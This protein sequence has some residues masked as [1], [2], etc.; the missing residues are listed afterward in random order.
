MIQKSLMAGAVS[1]ALA[2]GAAF[3]GGQAAQQG[4]QGGFQQ[5][6]GQGSAAIYIPQQ[7]QLQGQQAAGQSGGQ[8]QQFGQQPYGQSGGG[9]FGQQ[10]SGQPGN[11]G[12]Q[13]FRQQPQQFQ[14]QPY[15]QSG[16]SQFAQQ[17]FDQQQPGNQ[18]QQA[19][20]Q[21]QQFQQQQARQFQQQPQQFQQQPSAQSGAGQFGQQGFGQQQP[22]QQQQ[23]QQAYAQGGGAQTQFR[24]QGAGQ[25]FGQQASQARQVSNQQIAQEQ[26]ISRGT[27][28]YLSPA[29][30]RQ[31]Q[32]AL[33]RE[34]FDPGPVTGQWNQST[35]Q[36]ATNFQRSRGL[37]PTGSPTVGLLSA[38]GGNQLFA[39]GGVSSGGQQWSQ[40]QAQ[41]PG[42]PLHI[43][44]AQVRQIQQALNQEGYVIDQVDG[45]WSQS[46]AQAVR[47][48]QQSAGLIPTG[49][50]N[51]VL[52][53]SLG[54]TPG[55]GMQ[56]S[57]GGGQQQW[58][59]EDAQAPATLFFAGPATIRQ[60][61]QALSDAGYNTGGVTGLWNQQT[62][63]AA[64]NFQRANG[65]EPTGTLTVQLLAATGVNDWL[66]TSGGQQMA[67]MGAAGGQ[68][69][70]GQAA[71]Q[72]G[73]ERRFQQFGQSG[74][75]PGYSRGYDQGYREGYNQGINQ[76]GASGAVQGASDPGTT[77]T[78]TGYYVW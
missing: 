12:Q 23:Q 77:S 50:P 73:T 63:R 24:P 43:S 36:A 9:Q 11:Q 17:G 51:S 7:P 30:V 44:P 16:G 38:L 64:E 47:N 58:T 72:Q 28:I 40:E 49:T 22:Q 42:I 62:M 66:D 5:S 67:G 13:A 3:A 33:S 31:I 57:G 4:T 15:V 48:Y 70:G 6:G 41:G 10:A 21:P 20:Q 56:A 54:V 65:L 76:S 2:T 1:A 59:Q 69:E 74:F 18:G 45:Q 61:Q 60:V 68:F 19:F 71:Y 46:T 32:Q 37:E 55:Q 29:G 25:Q 52:L 78:I 26:A 8:S 35:A 34:G 53:S 14:Q 27:Q 39:S 75:G